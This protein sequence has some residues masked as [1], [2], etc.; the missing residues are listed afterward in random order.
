[1]SYEEFKRK[2]LE[3]AERLKWNPPFCEKCKIPMML[4]QEEGG[5]S[6]KLKLF[7]KCTSCGQRRTITIEWGWSDKYKVY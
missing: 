1:M 2:A 7:F 3:H 5:W 4:I 6:D